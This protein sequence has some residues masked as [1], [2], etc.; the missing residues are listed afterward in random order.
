MTD[1]SIGSLFEQLV[2]RVADRVA[3]RLFQKLQGTGSDYVDQ[4]TSPLGPRR[5]IAAIRSGKLQGAQVG[6]QYIARAS[7]VDG[8]IRNSPTECIPDEPADEVDR[9]ASELGLRKA[10]GGK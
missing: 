8:F 1:E 2:D 10:K 3:D 5:H 4:S 6:R 9:L 7:D